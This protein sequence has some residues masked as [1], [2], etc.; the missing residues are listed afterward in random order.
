M[1][2]EIRIGIMPGSP[3]VVKIRPQRHSKVNS[4]ERVIV[5]GFVQSVTPGGVDVWWDCLDD[6]GMLF[7]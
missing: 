1:S 7:L 3:P 5:K 4:D 2:K 6:G